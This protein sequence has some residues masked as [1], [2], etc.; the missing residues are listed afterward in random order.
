MSKYSEEDL[1][2]ELG[3][4]WLAK[5]DR[6]WMERELAKIRAS[7]ASI[8]AADQPKHAPTAGHTA[9]PKA[10]EARIAI[11]GSPEFIRATEK[12]LAALQGTPS[13]VLATHLKGIRQVS[14]DVIGNSAIGGYLKD[15]IFH[16]GNS[17]WQNNSTRYAS[18]IAHEGAHAANPQTFGTE[19]ERIAFKAQAQALRELGAPASVVS[20]YE[21]EACN[22][23]HH[24]GWAGPKRAA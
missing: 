23:T 19:G 11:E 17:S 2:R 21:A 14:D 18:D 12:A 15:G 3:R 10:G 1:V 22:P 5:S 20:H 4:S 24:L 8:P 6:R 13:W 7:G 9:A 16:V